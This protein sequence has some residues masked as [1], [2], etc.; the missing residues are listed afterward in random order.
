MRDIELGLDVVL[1]L[2]FWS[3]R[4]RDEIRA[5]AVALGAGVRLYRLECLEAEAWRRIEQRNL[6]LD[7][8]AGAGD[9]ALAPSVIVGGVQRAAST[10]GGNRAQQATQDL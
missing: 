10:A 2:G 5:T 1:D 6:D 4:Q 7:G 3:R 8:G 9:G